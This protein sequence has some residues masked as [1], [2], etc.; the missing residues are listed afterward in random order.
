MRQRQPSL[1][2][3]V[4][5]YVSLQLNDSGNPSIP[6]LPKLS[7]YLFSAISISNFSTSLDCRQHPFHLHWGKDS[8]HCH[9]HY[10]F[11]HINR[12]KFPFFGFNYSRCDNIQ[13]F[14]IFKN[15]FQGHELSTSRAEFDLLRPFLKRRRY[16][17]RGLVQHFSLIRALT[18]K[19]DNTV[20]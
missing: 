3:S 5:K 1:Q 15:V 4:Q 18:P 16:L 11:P 20:L 2:N 13:I 7:V 6:Y 19:F 14:F 8:T 9:P 17:L 10:S 12:I